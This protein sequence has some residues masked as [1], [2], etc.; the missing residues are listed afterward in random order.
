[1]TEPKDTLAEALADVSGRR[2]SLER[3]IGRLEGLLTSARVALREATSQETVLIAVT[4]ARS[5]ANPP[6]LFESEST[7]AAPESESEVEAPVVLDDWGNLSRT[8][9][10]QKAVV[11]IL[12]SKSFASP[13]DI[14]ELLAAR[15]RNDDRDLIGAALSYLRTKG[16]IVNLGRAQ[17]G[18]PANEVTS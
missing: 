4:K 8:F 7:T 18:I 14:Q 5:E 12:K 2:V 16:E 13:G 6:P 3:E 11:E 17:W 9:V 15:G 10:V 1:M